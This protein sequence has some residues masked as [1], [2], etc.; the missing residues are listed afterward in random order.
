M[1]SFIRRHRPTGLPAEEEPRMNTNKHEYSLSCGGL[2]P[3]ASVELVVSGGLK[4]PNHPSLGQR[5]RSGFPTEVNADSV[6]QLTTFQYITRAV[7]Y[8]FSVR[9]LFTPIPGALP[10]ARLRLPLRGV[11]TP[12]A[13]GSTSS[14]CT[15]GAPS[16]FRFLAE[17]GA[18]LQR[19]DLCVAYALPLLH[20]GLGS[21]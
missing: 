4:A 12:T 8:A 13:A 6:P 16:E 2:P 3:K 5:P 7:K 10:Q 15:F 9:S 11:N 21:Y 18:K 19:A 20:P 14:T 17:V 1:K